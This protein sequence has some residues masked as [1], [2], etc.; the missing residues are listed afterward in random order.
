MRAHRD[1]E[2][3]FTLIELLVTVVILGIIMGAIGI[4]FITSLRSQE[5]SQRQLRGSLDAQRLAAWL[6]PDVQSATTIA[7][8]PGTATGCSGSPT[9]SATNVNTLRLSWTEGVTTYHAAYR[10][11]QPVATEPWT[12]VRYSCVAGSA[13]VRLVL[14]KQLTA[15]NA[16]TVVNTGTRL[17]IAAV[18]QGSEVGQTYAFEVVGTRRTP[19]STTTVTPPPTSPPTSSP[20]D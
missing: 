8:A 16:A 1:G 18:V 9:Q 14:V 10:T 11:E 6:L 4:A 17:G 3:G 15:A 5:G 12:L 2:R 13:P 20:P 7:T 19:T